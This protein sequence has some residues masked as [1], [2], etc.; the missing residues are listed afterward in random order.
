MHHHNRAF[1]YPIMIAHDIALE[2]SLIEELT[3][4]ASGVS[5]SFVRLQV[6][7]PPW[8]S[9][10]QVPES[11]LGFP[12]AYRHM[13][14]WKAGLLWLMPEV[15]AYDYIWSLDTD[16]F[17]LAPLTYDVF[18]LMAARNAT[19]GYIDINVEDSRVAAGLGDCVRA[20][21]RKHVR[22]KPTMLHRFHAPG[23]KR[24]DGSKFYTNFQVARRDFGASRAYRQLFDHIDRDGGIYRQRW[25]A[26]PILFLQARRTTPPPLQPLIAP[27]RLHTALRYPTPAPPTRSHASPPTRYYPRP[28]ASTH[29]HPRR[30][31]HAGDTLPPA[32]ADAPL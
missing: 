5:L 4:I 17:L 16:S 24:W 32:R 2:P 22:I 3:A 8:M 31:T 7:L 21:L 9:A 23:T 15:A 20:F 13:I 18:A 12:V 26:D 10:K 29:A 25:G 11:V 14:R 19:Y 27:R 6:E 28:P 1:R 30:R